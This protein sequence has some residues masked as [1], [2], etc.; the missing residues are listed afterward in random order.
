[1]KEK[2]PKTGGY[3]NNTIYTSDQHAQWPE[4]TKK[5]CFLSLEY[6]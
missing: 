6:K 1:M 4:V 5:Y 2:I 3:I